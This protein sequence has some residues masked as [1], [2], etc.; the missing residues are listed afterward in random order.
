MS[1][2]RHYNVGFWLSTL[3]TNDA[4]ADTPQ[5]GTVVTIPFHFLTAAPCDKF[6]CGDGSCIYKSMVCNQFK[7]CPDG[8]DETICGKII[9]SRTTK[10]T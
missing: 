1:I 7:E 2:N 8:T 3:K 6:Q 9:I 5:A 10:P 4:C